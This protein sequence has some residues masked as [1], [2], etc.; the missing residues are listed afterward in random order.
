VIVLVTGGRDYRDANK[1]REVLDRVHKEHHIQLLVHG[2]ATGAD[3]LA[4]LWASARGIQP[5][6]CPALWDFYDKAAGTIRNTAMLWLKPQLCVEFLG[7]TG[8]AN[9]VGQAKQAGIRV[10][11]A[12]D[13]SDLI[14]ACCADERRN[15]NGGCDSCGDPCL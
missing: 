3:T 10:I 5:V 7:G 13:N 15:M 9:M 6:G 1:V 8:T 12:V 2:C 4:A 11:E 14:G